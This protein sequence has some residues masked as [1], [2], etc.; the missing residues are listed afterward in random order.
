MSETKTNATSRPG[1][2]GWLKGEAAQ[3]NVMLAVTC[4]LVLIAMT[5]LRPSMFLSSYNFES[6]AFFMPE[7]G[8]LSIAMMIAMLTGGIDLSIVG[9]A[10]LAGITAGTLF[11]AMAGDGGSGA[12]GLG[13]VTLGVSAALIV[14]L[15]AGLLN[16]FLISVLKITPILATLGTGQ[17]FIGMCLVLTGGPAIVGF[18]PGWN[19]IGNGKLLGIPVPL[20]IFVLVCIAL[21][22]LLA[23]TSFGLRLKLIGT[24]PKAAV[25]A[26]VKR[27][28]MILYSYM[29]TGMLAAMAGILLSARTNAA[30]SD[31]GASYL[32]QAVLIAV[33]GGTNPAGGRGNVLGVALALISLTLLSSGFQMMRVSNHLIDFVWGAFLIGVIALNSWRR[34]K[35]A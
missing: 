12:L 7:L 4:V 20:V 15:L 27:G 9:V 18:P 22:L 25:Y 11:G 24:N 5:A 28:Q 19:A 29:L 16:G 33:L 14:G 2:R 1:L 34:R 35:G 13:P 23:R 6:M 17:V 32:L 21:S 3:T 31:Y 26:G 10:N 8:I 30:K